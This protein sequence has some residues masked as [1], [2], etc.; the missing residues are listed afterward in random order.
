MHG[1]RND[2][3]STASVSVPDSKGGSTVEHDRRRRGAV[4]QAVAYE[5]HEHLPQAR[6][7]HPHRESESS[8]IDSAQSRSNSHSRS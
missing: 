3:V 1:I 4:E 8:R 2:D 6:A 5:P 7:I